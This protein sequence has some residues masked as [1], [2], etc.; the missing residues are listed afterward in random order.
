M[1]IE[2][3]DVG[4]RVVELRERRRRGKLPT[5]LGQKVKERAWPLRHLDFTLAAGQAVAV[6]DVDSDRP[7]VFLRIATG[8]LRPDEGTVSLPP[9]SLLAMTPRRKTIRSLSVGQTVRMVAGLYGLNDR[10]V[11]RRFDEIVAFAE[12][13]RQLHRRSESQS[14]HV[15]AQIAFAA[16][17][18][19]P[20]DVIAFDGNAAVGPPPFKEK[21]Y[22][23]LNE[24]K[25]AGRGLLIAT[26]DARQIKTVA[27]HGLVLAGESSRV[28]AVDEFTTV[29]TDH[30][31]GRTQLRKARKKRKKRDGDD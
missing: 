18:C 10:M 19:S 12:V 4:V 22:S 13:E 14:K 7:G 26:T 31:R 11:N 1:L 28:L 2:M 23:R 3:S 20:A 30:K 29:V 25:D 27:D 9:R 6:I 16:A 8:L 17:V 15:I 24:L 5:F 21:C